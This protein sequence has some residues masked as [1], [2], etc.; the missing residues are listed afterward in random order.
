M[1]VTTALD[2]QRNIG[3]YQEIAQREPVEI[4]RHGRPALV[5]LSAEEYER[6]KGGSGRDA[7]DDFWAKAERFRKSL[8]G[9]PFTPSEVLV[10][11]GRDER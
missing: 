9:R 6:L 3:R 8:E 2:F 7:T 1:A 10:R 11:E 5:L 4:T